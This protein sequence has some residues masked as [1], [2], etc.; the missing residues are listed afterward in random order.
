MKEVAETTGLKTAKTF[1][2]VGT[3]IGFDLISKNLV[4]IGQAVS[5][6]FFTEMFITV[7]CKTSI[8]CVFDYAKSP[9]FK[10]I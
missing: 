2:S 9:L 6:I 5:L 1:M 3:A 10:L 4:T 8:V 7:S